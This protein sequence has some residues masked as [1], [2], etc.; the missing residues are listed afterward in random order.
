META[1]LEAVVEEL[2]ENRMA[3]IQLAIDDLGWRP[4]GADYDGEEL[5]RG[6]LE[7]SADLLRAMVTINPLV[8]RGV[9]V[10]TSYI[11]GKGIEFEGVEESHKVFT[12][13]LN[14]RF[15]F[16]SEALAENER[17]LATDGNFFVLAKG[18]IA[19]RRSSGY[20][21]DPTVMRIPMKQITA[22]Y[23]NPENPEEI[24]FYRR[25]WKETITRADGN[26]ETKERKAWYPSDL[27]E[28][29]RGKRRPQTIQKI[30]VD[31]SGA[32]ID[33]CVNKQVGWKWG[34]PDGMS[35][36]FWA[37]AHKE[38]LED[39]ARLVKA[40][41]RFA[42]K[43]TAPTP[44]SVKAVAAK[45]GGNTGAAVP[46]G[47]R[48][49]IGGTAV[50]APGGNIQA[51]GRTSGSV[52]FSTGLPLASYVAAGFEVPL[53]DLLSDSSLSNR[54]AAE[55]LTASKLAAMVERQK[56]WA[57]FF[58]RLFSFWGKDVEVFF[59]VIEPESTHKL[60]QAIAQ[61]S[62]LN[63]LHAQEVRDMIV[64]I[65]DLDTDKGLPTEEELG[66][67][68]LAQTKTEEQAQD[69]NAKP[70]YAND[71]YGDNTNRS[72]LKGGAHEYDSSDGQGE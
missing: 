26:P 70:E 57:S 62:S 71:S 69:S 38:F 68:I 12:N 17:C 54:S 28:V 31:W 6:T 34:V 72:D 37:K 35:V 14:Q 23:C 27:Y 18:Q 63:I 30:K 24:W 48:E 8:K 3:D 21:G 52:D 59:P 40:Y 15:L 46:H 22:H 32:I 20:R 41:S 39:Q 16:S 56:S 5:D 58:K 33:H 9:A 61:A 49:D 11:W 7:D 44:K 50:M 66:L 19:G 65:L 60:I 25:E 67:L 36:I 64:E 51:I 10:R 13:P 47:A 55:T 29:P 4:L 53:T 1:Q 43:A 42:F 2:V 45:V